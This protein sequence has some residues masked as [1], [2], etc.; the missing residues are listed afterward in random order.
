M[1]RF[2]PH[3]RQRA[4]FT[5]IELL[6]VIAIIAILAAILFPVFAQAREKARQTACLSNE[7][8]I[9]TAMLMYAQDYDENLVTWVSYCP[10]ARVPNPLDPNDAPGGTDGPGRRPYWHLK[11]MPYTKNFDIF[12]CP[13]DVAAHAQAGITAPFIYRAIFISYAL[14]Y[15]YLGTYHLFDG[16]TDSCGITEW[17][18]SITMA[19]IVDPSNIIAVVDGGGRYGATNANFGICINPPDIYASEKEFWWVD[20]AGWGDTTGRSSDPFNPRDIPTGNYAMRH[21]GGG[22]AIHVDGHAKW[23]NTGRAAE[24]TNYTP[25]I[26]PENIR[27][28]D[29]SKYHWDPR[30]DSGSHHC[31]PGTPNCL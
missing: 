5:L 18:D 24:G 27:V 26:V 23:Y 6:V 17:V 15:G 4:G 29:Y 21:N 1:N 9:G 13:S 11:L 19:S 31:W 22:N 28:T 14:N 3:G 2:A 7:K 12:S 10:S 25:S 30:Y 8:Q 20:V 16:T